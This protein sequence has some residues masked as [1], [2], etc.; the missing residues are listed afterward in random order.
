MVQYKNV[1]KIISLK[2]EFENNFEN[3]NLSFFLFFFN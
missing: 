2:I 1:V 3:L